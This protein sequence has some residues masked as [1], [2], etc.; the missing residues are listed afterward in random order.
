[1][2]IHASPRAERRPIEI[3]FTPTTV[4]PAR[5][6]RRPAQ[7]LNPSFRLVRFQDRQDEILELRRA[8]YTSVGKLGPGR[9]KQVETDSRD[10]RAWVLVAE[11]A[12]QL[13]ACVRLTP[14]LPGPVQT[15]VQLWS[16]LNPD[17]PGTFELDYTE[18]S[19]ACIHPD[20]QGRGLFW[21]LAAQMIL[22][23]AKL[24][25]RYL[26]GGAD[27][28]LWSYWR[29]CGFRD[30]GFVYRHGLSDHAFRM[31][32]FDTEAPRSSLALDPRLERE[33]ASS[34]IGLAT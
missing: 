10:E 25:R 17:L 33:L 30:T 26:I 31:I 5:D 12:G 28:S 34:P 16:R 8:A 2:Q 21:S 24:G 19:W 27:D 4:Q 22:A 32:V 7:H 15:Q 11:E 6:R 20:H 9:A 14:P 13:V 23:A 1:M 3:Y 18:V 29:R